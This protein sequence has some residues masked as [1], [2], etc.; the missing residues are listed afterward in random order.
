MSNT[1]PLPT[2]LLIDDHTLF[3]EGMRLMLGNSPL[4]QASI[5]GVE[6]LAEALALQPPPDLV[7]LD[8]GLPGLGGIAGL[9]SLRQHWP[10][11]II[12]M[13]SAH[14][15]PEIVRDAMRKGA[16][17][18]I[19]KTVE[20]THIC[21]VVRHWLL[22]RGA[23][24]LQRPFHENHND[25]ATG[26]QLL[27]PRQFEVL[28]LMAQGLSNKAIAYKLHLSEYTVRNH[29]V[30]ILRHFNAQTRTETVMAAQRLG[31]LPTVVL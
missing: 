12:V 22:Q 31:L 18:F 24:P 15:R 21:Q 20:P 19:S 7:L 14:D 6:S 13:L 16:S 3:R 25:T 26:A 8:V 11:A 23:P 1:F 10:N 30:A 4:V 27:T 5:L 17:E 9:E 28:Q 2:V 29:V